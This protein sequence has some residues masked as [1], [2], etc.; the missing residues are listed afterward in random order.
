MAGSLILALDDLD[1]TQEILDTFNSVAV[2]QDEA[3][4]YMAVAQKFI[5]QD[6][7]MEAERIISGISD[8]SWDQ[9]DDAMEFSSKKV[10]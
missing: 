1:K 2:R 10:V 8:S 9:I 7:M 5:E 4:P 3:F 6:R